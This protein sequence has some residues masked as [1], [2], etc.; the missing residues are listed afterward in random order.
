M[1]TIKVNLKD[2]YIVTRINAD[3]EEIA[4]YYFPRRDVESIDILDGGSYES[5]YIRRVPL[6]IYRVTEEERERFQLF[7][8][9]RYSFRVE[10]LQGQAND[11]ITSCGLC[12][13]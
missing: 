5:E 2:D 3:L 1:M 11:E 12:R 6:K 13:I 4:K 9:I 8:N 7:H 10:Y